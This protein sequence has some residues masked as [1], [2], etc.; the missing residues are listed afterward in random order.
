MFIYSD[1]VSP[2][3]K[4]LSTW[5]TLENWLK[6][7]QDLILKPD[8]THSKRHSYVLKRSS[9]GLDE[10]SSLHI[11]QSDTIG[12]SSCTLQLS[13]SSLSDHS[14]EGI[15]HSSVLLIFYKNLVTANVF[16]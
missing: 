6:K 4:T 16:N 11:D 8:V 14:S 10:S 7:K 15:A 12:D 1:P 2:L 5:Q 3:Q 13:A 9:V